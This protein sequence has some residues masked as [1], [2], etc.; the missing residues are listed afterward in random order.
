[1]SAS[2]PKSSRLK[3]SAVERA[4]ESRSRRVLGMGADAAGVV[5]AAREGWAALP[6]WVRRGALGIVGVLFGGG[7]AVWHRRVSAVWGVRTAQIPLWILIAVVL[8]VA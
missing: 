2:D 5:I 1:M 3:T 7:I 6:A 8:V 4:D